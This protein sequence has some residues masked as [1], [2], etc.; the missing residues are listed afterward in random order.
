M[1]TDKIIESDAFLD[2]PITARLLYYDLSMR[3]DNEYNY[4]PK[5]GQKLN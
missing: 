2:M 4:C 1:F 5:C 3:A